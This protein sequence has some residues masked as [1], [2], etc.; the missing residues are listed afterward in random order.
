MTSRSQSKQ[1]AWI[2]VQRDE[3]MPLKSTA[4]KPLRARHTVVTSAPR[5][6]ADMGSIIWSVFKKERA[7]G[8]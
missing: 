8:L 5:P 7:F 3:L 4:T 1:Q 6:D 2:L